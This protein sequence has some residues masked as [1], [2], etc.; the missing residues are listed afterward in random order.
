MISINYKHVFTWIVKGNKQDEEKKIMI[1]SVIPNARR[2]IEMHFQLIFK[3]ISEWLQRTLS[4]RGIQAFLSKFQDFGKVLCRMIDQPLLQTG[5]IPRPFILTKTTFAW[6]HF[7]ILV[8]L[9]RFAYAATAD[10]KCY[11]PECVYLYKRSVFRKVKLN[12][13]NVLHGHGSRF[14]LSN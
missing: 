6:Q 1:Y 4:W 7:I 5:S 11:S 3:F 9:I 14:K 8:N 12:A 13:L 2:K 10:V